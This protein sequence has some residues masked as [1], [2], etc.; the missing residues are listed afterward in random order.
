MHTVIR[1]FLLSWAQSAR[2]FVLALCLATSISGCF[3]DFQ[4]VSYGPS[5]YIYGWHQY[6]NPRPPENQIET[7]VI[8]VAQ[9]QKNINN[10]DP[11]ILFIVNDFTR[12]TAVQIVDVVEKTV[13]KNPYP[14]RTVSRYRIL[15]GQIIAMSDPSEEFYGDAELE[16][17]ILR[18][19]AKTWAPDRVVIYNNGVSTVSI[20]SH[21]VNACTADVKIY[22]G[23]KTF[24]KPAAE[25][26]VS[27]CF[28]R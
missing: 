8:K 27:F 28:A 19:I 23:E 5:R 9:T 6:V 21:G 12:E 13:S 18:A 26:R 11:E 17:A 1:Y 3:G 4:L 7:D 10:T 22:T 15:N 24:G 16:R 25:K 14:V 20:T 2:F